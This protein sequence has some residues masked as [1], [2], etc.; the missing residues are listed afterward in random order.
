MTK[1]FERYEI[2]TILHLLFFIMWGV[3]T[4]GLIPLLVGFGPTGGFEI[5]EILQKFVF[6]TGPGGLF[7]V[8]II[9]IT[10]ASMIIFKD[11]ERKI[12]GIILHNPDKG[13]LS[14]A[15]DKLTGGNV[16][17]VSLIVF[18]L[19]GIFSTTTQTF[20]Y[21]LPK[22]EQQFTKTADVIFSMWPASPAETF[23]YV[24]FL[25]FAL[26]FLGLYYKKKKLDHAS[27]LWVSIPISMVLGFFYG[28]ILHTL[29][30]RNDE[31]SM[32]ATIIFW[33]MQGILIV[34]FGTI[35]P[36]LLMHDTNNLFYKL[37]K[38]FSSDIVTGIIVAV[39]I[40]LIFVYMLLLII[41]RGK[42][43]KKDEVKLL[44][45]NPTA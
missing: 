1:L 20:F 5:E 26:F 22:V 3:L 17:M 19:L 6:Y 23:G 24:F 34:M 32:A 8:G 44:D 12:N 2:R 11:D 29:R 36:S 28:L 40:L 27:F 42:R 31:I 10:I 15:K 4:M 9:A 13:I 33:I 35:I 38:L 25:L 14:F 39:V 18:S 41:K 21:N 30:Y 37:N 16:I 45:V 7:L 43:K